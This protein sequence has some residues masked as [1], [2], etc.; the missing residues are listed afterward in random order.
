VSDA[1]RPPKDGPIGTTLL[2]RSRTAAEIATAPPLQDL[3]ALVI[4]D[5]SDEEYE[6]FLDAITS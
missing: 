5:L 3:D 6:V 1:A 2:P 4:D